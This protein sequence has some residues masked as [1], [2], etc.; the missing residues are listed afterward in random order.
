ML[1]FL[2][3]ALLI[4]SVAVFVVVASFHVISVTGCFSGQC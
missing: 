3:W 1:S 4:S 2:Q